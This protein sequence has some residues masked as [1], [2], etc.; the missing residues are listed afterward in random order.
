MN[1]IDRPAVS[2]FGSAR[3][4]NDPPMDGA[5]TGRGVRRTRVGGGH[6]RRSGDHGGSEPRLSRRRGLSVGFNILLPHEQGDNGYLDISLEFRT[7]TPAR[8]CS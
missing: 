8:R 7:S 1:R 5:A 3:T 2:I 4:G 6:R